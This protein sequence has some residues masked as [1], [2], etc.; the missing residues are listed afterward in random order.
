MS[1]AD[2]AYNYNSSS[3]SA[4]I[5]NTSKSTY[6]ESEAACRNNGGHLV[7]FN[8]SAEQGEVEKYFMDSGFMLPRCAARLGRCLAC[9]PDGAAAAHLPASIVMQRACA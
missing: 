5:W 9:C 4:Y 2:G 1:A 3:G 6:N 8:T 7:S